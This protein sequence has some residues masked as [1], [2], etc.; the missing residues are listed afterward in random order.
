M[1]KLLRHIIL[2]A[3][4]ACSVAMTAVA[5]ESAAVQS[6]D[7]PATSA[8]VSGHQLVITVADDAAHQVAVYA[9]TGQLVKQLTVG[10]GSTTIDLTPGYYIVKIDHSSQ[11]I[12]VR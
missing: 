12:V 4:L 9:L 2:A 3:G 11:R 1:K 7:T 6:V 10:Y 5:T 8:K